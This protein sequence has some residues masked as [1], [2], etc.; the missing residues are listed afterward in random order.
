P[1]LPATPSASK[2]PPTNQSFE[3]AKASAAPSTPPLTATTTSLPGKPPVEVSSL[4][5]PTKT[6]PQVATAP[7][8]TG[9]SMSV[10]AGG[11]YENLFRF[12][13]KAG[14]K[15]PIWD[16]SGT[17]DFRIVGGY[18]VSGSSPEEVIQKY[19]EPYMDSYNFHVEISTGEKAV[20][21]H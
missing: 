6:A 1:A 12:T 20:W 16:L 4:L 13:E 18:T 5:G 14:W 15:P 2:A 10:T 7:V 17:E 9:Y 21:I 8:P 19:L 11:L 3:T